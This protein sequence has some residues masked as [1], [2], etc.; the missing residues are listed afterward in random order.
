MIGK[1]LDGFIDIDRVLRFAVFLII[2]VELGDI[3]IFLKM[4][5]LF[6]AELELFVFN[7]NAL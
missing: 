7:R 1:L 3:H 5:H 2:D 6:I 4:M